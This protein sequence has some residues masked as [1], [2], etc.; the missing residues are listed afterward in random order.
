MNKIIWRMVKAFLVGVG[1]AHLLFD[2]L[3]LPMIPALFIAGV[4]LYFTSEIY[5]DN[6]K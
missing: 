4:L 2:M 1:T 3:A 5:I 6:P